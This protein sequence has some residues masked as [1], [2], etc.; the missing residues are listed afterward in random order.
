MLAIKPKSWAALAVAA[1]FAAPAAAELSAADLAK[2]GTTLTPLGGE[3]AGNAT[4][5]IP[6][7]DGGITKPI[8]GYKPGEHYLDPFKDDK[9][10]ITITGANADQYKAQITNGAYAMLKKYPTYKM[11]V[12]PTRRTA[13]APEGHYKE[14]KE[15]AAK[16]KLAA[17]GNGVVGCTGGVPFPI[18][19]DGNEAIWNSLLRYRGGDAC[20]SNR[21]RH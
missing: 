6:A 20:R 14:T 21:S 8:P 15:C 3:K 1:A 4:G 16:A 7:W 5:T 12:Y 9:P 17:G 19:K 13:S 10:T 2:L 11:V 18:P